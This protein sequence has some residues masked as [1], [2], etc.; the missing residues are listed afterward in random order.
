MSFPRRRESSQ[1]SD[2]WTSQYFAITCQELGRGFDMRSELDKV[3]RAC[4]TLLGRQI[5]P[6]QLAPV[7]GAVCG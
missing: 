4:T 7:S 6:Q 1:G 2:T 5:T 3:A